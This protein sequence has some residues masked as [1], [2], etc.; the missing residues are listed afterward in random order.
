MKPKKT[1]KFS[2]EEGSYILPSQ[3]RT[4]AE[5]I[6][7]NRNPITEKNFSKEETKQMR[8]AIARSR[9]R[10]EKAALEQESQNKPSKTDS[11]RKLKYDT[12]VDYADYGSDSPREQSVFKDYSPLPSDAA[13]NTLGKFRYEK[14]PEGRLIVTDSY[15]FKDDLVNKHSKIPRSK[16]Y[17]QLS[18]FEKLRKLAEDTVALEKHGLSTLP[19]RVGSAFVGATSRPV[20][21]DLGEAPFKKGGKVSA[22]SQSRTTSSMRGD[23]LA[24]K[25]FTK[26]KVR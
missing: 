6:A 1:R 20:R 9:T 3:V 26:G 5:T 22:K 23:G 7:G 24:K 14:T 18:T 16:D 13:R 8:E 10:Q 15:D 21:V 4:F 17:E 25:G 19:S 12:T 2:G 11:A